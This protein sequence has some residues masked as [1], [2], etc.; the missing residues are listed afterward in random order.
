MLQLLRMM[1]AAAAK[2]EP[3]E[4]SIQGD[5]GMRVWVASEPLDGEQGCVAS[6]VDQAHECKS[7]DR[8]WV[9]LPKDSMMSFDTRLSMLTLECLSSACHDELRHRETLA[10]QRVKE[11]KTRAQEL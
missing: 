3:V 1:R 7:D 5:A 2:S 10:A 9:L 4:A 11:R 6:W 8:V